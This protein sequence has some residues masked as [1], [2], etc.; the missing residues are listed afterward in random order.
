LEQGTHNSSQQLAEAIPDKAKPVTPLLA[1]HDK[2]EVSALEML[3]IL[4]GTHPNVTYEVA[5]LFAE[6]GREPS[7]D[8]FWYTL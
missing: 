2:T 1:H 4:G 6:L 7:G 8:D 3:L 5:E